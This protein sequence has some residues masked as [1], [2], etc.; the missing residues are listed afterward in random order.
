MTNAKI[1]IVANFTGNET[2][3]NR[4]INIANLLANK[5]FDVEVITSDFSHGS[6][7]QKDFG[8][9]K[10]N[11][12]ITRIHEPGYTSNV[13]P[14]RLYSHYV[15]GKNVFK[16]IKSMKIKP[17]L[18]YC[19]VPSLT[20]PNLLGKYCKRNKI[21]FITDIQDLWPEAFELLIKN[22]ILKKLLFKPFHKY[23]NKA[24]K[25]S[26]LIIGVSET[27][28]KRGLSSCVSGYDSSSP[29]KHLNNEETLLNNK[30]LTIYLGNDLNQFDKAKNIIDLIKPEDEFWI[31]YIGTLGYSY[32]IKCVIDS[33]SFLKEKHNIKN[34]KFIVMGSGPLKEEFQNYAIK[35][36]INVE[37]TG[38]LPYDKMVANLCK[39]NIVVN[40]IVKGGAQSITNKVGDYAFS[41]VPVV[42]TQPNREYRNLLEQFNCGI[43]CEVG[44]AKQMSDAILKIYKNPQLKNI[45]GKN[46]R[47][48]GEERF[49]R[50]KTYPILIDKI[51][52]IINGNKSNNTTPSY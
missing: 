15:W 5:G 8:S 30:G 34:I 47:R 46:G 10:L 3:K 52:T 35:K 28:M 32:D 12:K 42:N 50:N 27:Y 6:K 21:N 51:E 25:Y 23:A 7:K 41:G 2:M 11:F 33:I 4:F 24:Y 20:A 29:K 38:P 40:P 48:L 49:D 16:Y 17:D 18:I 37:F 43:N 14:T 19:A 44:D 26:D 45:L 13:S 39:C 22:N 9:P 1:L 36:N 31:G